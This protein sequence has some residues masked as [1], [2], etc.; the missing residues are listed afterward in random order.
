MGVPAELGPLV[1]CVFFNAASMTTLGIDEE[2]DRLCGVQ[3]ATNLHSLE[4]TSSSSSSLSLSVSLSSLSSS[5]EED[6][7]SVATFADNADTFLN[8]SGGNCTA[9]ARYKI[10][11]RSQRDDKL[12]TKAQK[13]VLSLQTAD[14]CHK[15]DDF[16][17]KSGDFGGKS[18]DFGKKSGDFG[19]KSGDF[20]GK[21][22][23]F[24]KKSGNFGKKTAD[25][26]EKSAGFG[27]KT[28]GFC[29]KTA[30][31]CKAHEH[32][33]VASAKME[34]G[35]GDAN[36]KKH[37]PSDKKAEMHAE[38]R[39]QH[40]QQQP[41]MIQ[42]AAA[43]SPDPGSKEDHLFVTSPPVCWQAQ[44]EVRQQENKREA[45]A[46]G[47]WHA[48]PAANKQGA[49]VQQEQ[50]GLP[51]LS[52]FPSQQQEEEEE[53]EEGGKGGDKLFRWSIEKIEQIIPLRR[54][55]CAKGGMH[56]ELDED[57]RR[58]NGLENKRRDGCAALHQ[59]V[60]GRGSVMVSST[61]VDE[62]I[63]LVKSRQPAEM[64][65]SLMD[66]KRKRSLSVAT[67]VVTGDKSGN[68]PADEMVHACASSILQ[69]HLTS[70]KRSRCVATEMAKFANDED[71]NTSLLDGRG[72]RRSTA[73][74]SAPWPCVGQLLEDCGR[75]DRISAPIGEERVPNLTVDHLLKSVLNHARI[76]SE[77]C[78]NA[79][80]T[81]QAIIHNP[82]GNG[83]DARLAAANAVV[84]LD[85]VRENAV[86]SEEG[87]IARCRSGNT[88]CERTATR[89]SAED[90]DATTYASDTDPTTRVDDSATTRA[91]SDSTTCADSHVAT[92]GNHDAAL[93]AGSEE[94]TCAERHVSPCNNNDAVLV[95]I[96]SVTKHTARDEV[97]RGSDSIRR[98]CAACVDNNGTCGHTND[99]VPHRSAACT[100]SQTRSS[101]AQKTKEH[102]GS[103]HSPAL[104]RDGRS[105]VA[106]L[107]SG[108]EFGNQT[109]DCRQSGKDAEV[110]ACS[111][112]S[113]LSHWT[114]Q[115]EREIYN[116][117]A[118]LHS[119]G[120]KQPAHEDV[121]WF[122]ARNDGSLYRTA[123]DDCCHSERHAGARAVPSTSSLTHRTLQQ[124]RVIHGAGPKQPEHEDAHCTPM[125]NDTSHHRRAID[126]CWQAGKH[127][128]SMTDQTLQQERVARST[129]AEQAETAHS[130]PVSTGP[131]HR[132]AVDNHKFQADP[133]PPK[134]RMSAIADG[135]YKNK[136]AEKAPRW[137][138]VDHKRHKVLRQQRIYRWLC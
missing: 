132:A 104:V 37:S 92:L 32:E 62:T 28:A 41:K 9:G 136:K 87:I 84:E 64:S 119:R 4:D 96:S 34:E 113:S 85:G 5:S 20:G 83:D 93:P 111:P 89:A 120:A 137:I 15:T 66:G 135:A 138:R 98:G 109:Q 73:L 65:R 71:C 29:K 36:L 57:A 61:A 118:K 49:A 14:E 75:F 53:E 81:K 45:H 74:P 79:V 26:C 90:S 3:G 95:A 56:S 112:P 115:Q 129:G 125:R 58:V 127:A 43:G 107:P 76:L 106:C 10:L 55:H 22:G 31:F 25:V 82:R 88:T 16:G 100:T 123:P 51:L 6:N 50:M 33:L 116:T 78:E 108:I 7:C 124:Q 102:F 42:H 99:V 13:E 30:E 8:S 80:T 114:L 17:K 122:P 68:Y 69:Q 40:S 97:G 86:C 103:E 63:C 131:C 38:V 21:S 60:L 11:S 126:D 121:R 67:G 105:D 133:T 48:V 59:E 128:S 24:G 44:E 46:G 72:R 27:K 1:L 117:G 101:G 54:R 35:N 39:Q 110:R 94:A 130:T 19:R 52:A 70:G 12:H 47:P 91:D 23:D 2:L 134:A 18:G 77:T